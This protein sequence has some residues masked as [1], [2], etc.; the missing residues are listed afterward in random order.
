MWWFSS[1]TGGP[2]QAV[3]HLNELNGETA[4]TQGDPRQK[5]MRPGQEDLIAIREITF[6]TLDRCSGA[7]AAPGDRSPRW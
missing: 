1:E 7:P 6:E 3:C 2:Q 4:D 5:E